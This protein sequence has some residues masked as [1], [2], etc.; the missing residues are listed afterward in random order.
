MNI[1]KKEYTGKYG[2]GMVLIAAY[3]ADMADQIAEKLFEDTLADDP[4]SFTPAEKL[5]NSRC[6]NK[7]AGIIAS[8]YYIE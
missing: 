7:E 4:T 1:Y 5:S 8:N 6:Y 3:T 2:G